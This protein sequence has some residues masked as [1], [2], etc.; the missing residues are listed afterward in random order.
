MSRPRRGEVDADYRVRRRVIENLIKMFAPVAE[1]VDALDLKSTR[2]S[3]S[4]P[5]QVWPGASFKDPLFAGL[6]FTLKLRLPGKRIYAFPPKTMPL[7]QAAP[8]SHPP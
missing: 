7:L 8:K 4:V 5:V 6:F 1:S 2:G 3:P